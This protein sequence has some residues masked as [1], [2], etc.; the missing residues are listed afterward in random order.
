MKARIY[1]LKTFFSAYEALE[2]FY[3][4]ILVR[5]IDRINTKILCI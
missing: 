4:T 5:E 1:H 3:Q 2:H